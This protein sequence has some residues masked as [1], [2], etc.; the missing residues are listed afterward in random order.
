KCLTSPQMK[1][2]KAYKTYL[3]YATG[4]VPPKVSRKFKKASQSKK[5][6][7]PVPADEE[8]VQKGKRENDSEEHESKFEQD[9]D[10]SE[11]DSESDQ[12]DDDDEDD[13]KSEVFRFKD[14]GISLE[15]DVDE[16]KNDP[17]HTQVTVI[18]KQVRNQLP[19]ILLEEVSNFAPPMITSTQGWE[20]LEKN[21]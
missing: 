2:S 14:K 13:D 17:L 8:P 15:K 20:H 10:G 11:S 18:T 7:V 1:E 9:T 16:L 3:G 21:S 5:D 4:S 6:S 19:Q 12:Q